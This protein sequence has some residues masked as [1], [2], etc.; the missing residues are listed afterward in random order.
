MCC[1]VSLWIRSLRM[2]TPMGQEGDDC[3]P[4]SHTVRVDACAPASEAFPHF[5]ISF[6]TSGSFLWEAAA[7]H[8]SLPAEP[9]LHPAGRGEIQ[10]SVPLQVPRLLPLRTLTLFHRPFF[11]LFL[12]NKGQFNEAFYFSGHFCYQ[13]Q[14][15][16]SSCLFLIFPL[17]FLQICCFGLFLST[18]LSNK[19][20]QA[21][22]AC[23]CSAFKVYSLG[24]WQ[25]YTLKLKSF[26]ALLCFHGNQECQTNL[27]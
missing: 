26:V 10:V 21:V 15:H 27:H 19:V 22:V 14:K 6:P 20:A 16:S 17:F 1:A 9:V 8:L 4:M 3:H 7:P 12:L 18:R 11:F 2:C 25:L 13:L 24:G 23:R 5:N